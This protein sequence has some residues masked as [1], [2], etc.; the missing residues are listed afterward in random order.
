MT[1]PFDY[2]N[3]INK[4]S[5]INPRDDM[6]EFEGVYSPYIVS[7]QFSYFIDT[8]MDANE[9][10]I[11]STEYHGLTK[12]QH[13]DYLNNSIQKGSRYTKWVKP[14]KDDII[15]LIQTVYGYSVK[16]AEEVLDIFSEEDIKNLYMKVN[17]GGK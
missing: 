16:K 12:I 10:N 15:T 5:G 1:T 2:I 11:R 14:K 9:L 13:Y 8:I 6:N 4:K 3:T 7:R 17:E